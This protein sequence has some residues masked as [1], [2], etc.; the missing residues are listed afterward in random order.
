[1]WW[2]YFLQDIIRAMRLGW[3]FGGFV[4][5]VF[6]LHCKCTPENVSHGLG[7][8]RGRGGKPV[9]KFL[10]WSFQY[11]K[12][13]HCTNIYLGK[14]RKV[15]ESYW[16]KSEGRM[17]PREWAAKGQF[18]N[19]SHTTGLTMRST[20]FSTNIPLKYRNACFYYGCTLNS[21]ILA[22]PFFA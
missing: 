17:K 20:P 21:Q 8:H 9:G 18:S 7:N 12:P 10:A 3:H 13:K 15:Q 4:W 6:K 2:R 19:M 11:A 22:P 14:G 5:L 16:K 1:M